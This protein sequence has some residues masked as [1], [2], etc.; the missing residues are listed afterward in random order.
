MDELNEVKEL[1]LH[2]ARGIWR[3]RWIA[4]A[5]AWVVLMIGV[6]G[7]DQ[8]KNRYKA[9]TKV[10]IDSTSVLGPLLRGITVQSDFQAVVELMVKQLLSRPNLERAVRI[11]DLDLDVNSPLE[12]EELIESI[13]SRVTITAKK[14]SGIYTITYTDIDRRKARQMVPT[15][16]DIV[17]EDTLGS[18]INQSDTAIEFLDSQICN[19]M[20]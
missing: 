13:R 10:Y 16:L 8:I 9:E 18:T 19:G 17:V 6:A 5:V 12:M 7:V 14:R 15:L 4:I 3:F 1:G 2:Y 20:I 11:L